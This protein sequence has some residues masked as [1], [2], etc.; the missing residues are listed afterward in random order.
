VKKPRTIAALAAVVLLLALGGCLLCTRSGP[1]PAVTGNLRAEDPPQIERAVLS[2]RWTMVR[3]SVAGHDVKFFFSRPFFNAMSGRV[4]EIGAMPD[5]PIIG[6][7]QSVT[8]PSCA[9]YAILANGH[10]QHSL[11]YHLKLTTNGW[12]VVSPILYQ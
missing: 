2:Y 4:R 12:A 1:Q 3:E 10:S 11:R 7:G 6:W 5:R 8:N 9:A